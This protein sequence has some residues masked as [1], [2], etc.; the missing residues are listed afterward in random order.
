MGNVTFKQ[1]RKAPKKGYLEVKY[2]IYT[3]TSTHTK[4]L[5]NRQQMVFNKRVLFR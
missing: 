1:A 5:G 4:T 3:K 2:R